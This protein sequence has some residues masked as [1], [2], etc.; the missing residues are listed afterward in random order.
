M[1][2]SVVYSL[3]AVCNSHYLENL[4]YLRGWLRAPCLVNYLLLQKGIPWGQ[5]DAKDD[6]VAST[7]CPLV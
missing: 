2:V 3:W 4:N 7:Q 5:P 1:P 6:G